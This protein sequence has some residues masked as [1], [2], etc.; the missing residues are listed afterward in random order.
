MMN[1]AERPF[2]KSLKSNGSIYMG[3][4]KRAVTIKN[5][6]ITGALAELESKQGYENTRDIYKT[7]SASTMIDVHLPELRLVGNAEV[8]RIDMDD[9][10]TF[11][12]MEFR[13]ISHNEG[14]R[15][16]KRQDH[17]EYMAVPGRIFLN[18]EY[19]AFTTVNV[20]AGGLMILLNGTTVVEEGLT[21]VF[22][23][24]QMELEGQIKVIW[25]NHTANR[26]T[27]IGLQYI[28]KVS[29]AIDAIPF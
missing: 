22:D 29:V 14:N 5:M 25:V 12:A 1:Y 3:G 28:Y 16:Y 7:L 2:R 26:A 18:G 8:V 19:R 4:E 23:F 10:R 13:Y 20:S 21:T 27:T 15:P 6:S 9:E 17:R 24:E 11:I